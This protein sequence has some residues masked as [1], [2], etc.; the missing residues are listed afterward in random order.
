ML[1]MS[2]PSGGGV[3]SDYYKQR[4]MEEVTARVKAE[5]ELADLKLMWIDLR[6]SMATS[7]AENEELKKALLCPTWSA[8]HDAMIKAEVEEEVIG[9]CADIAFN[10]CLVPP[11]GGS[12]TQEEV[13]VASEA[14]SRIYHMP[15]KYKG[16]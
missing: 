14:C 13:D 15:R 6:D 2:K 7:G 4:L 8:Q 3:M 11:D 1:S 10:A 9:R 5:Q 12:P 16:E